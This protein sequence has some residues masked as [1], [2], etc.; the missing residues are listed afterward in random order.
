LALMISRMV[1]KS[2]IRVNESAKELARGNFQ[3]MFDGR[4]Y[5]EISQLSNTLNYA[6]SELSKTENL[7]R[8]LLANVSHDLRTPL[9]MII[10]YSEVMRDLPDENTQENVQVVIEEAQRLTSLVN[11]ML[12]VS[13]LQAGVAR[14][15]KRG[16][17]LK[18]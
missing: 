12:D 9:T 7:Q 3:V 4:D 5:K 11:D 6:A 1:S 13:K 2:I 14:M 18:P 16:K 17:S 8:E 15:E 10:A